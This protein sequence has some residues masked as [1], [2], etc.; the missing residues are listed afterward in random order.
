[1][2]NKTNISMPVRG[3]DYQLS[4]EFDGLKYN[5][6]WQGLGRYRSLQSTTYYDSLAQAKFSAENAILFE[7]SQ[8]ET[9]RTDR[10]KQIEFTE[11][12]F[13]CNRTGD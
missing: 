6:S 1:M 13:N 5:F 7:R 3:K 9:Q 11:E 8:A 10:T 2:Q 4:S 12:D